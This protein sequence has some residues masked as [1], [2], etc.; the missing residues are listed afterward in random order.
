VYSS[1]LKLKRV[2]SSTRNITRAACVA[3]AVSSI[4]PTLVRATT[5]VVTA[6]STPS[7]Q[8]LW[9]QPQVTAASVIT[10]TPAFP[11][12]LT[13]ALEKRILTPATISVAAAAQLMSEQV[14]E[15]FAALPAVLEEKTSLAASALPA[16]PEDK[17]PV[18]AAAPPAPVEEMVQVSAAAILPAPEAAADLL[19]PEVIKVELELDDF[20]TDYDR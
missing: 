7:V 18:V 3:A 11:E 17:V 8:Q 5:A 12:V 9:Q 19:L 15:S 4:A 2:P 20:K 1:G 13:S 16:I 10:A 14:L 6:T